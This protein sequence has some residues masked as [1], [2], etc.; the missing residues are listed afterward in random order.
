MSCLE[1]WGKGPT[2][3]GSRQGTGQGLQHSEAPGTRLPVFGVIPLLLAQGP[4]VY[5]HQ[6]MTS[7]LPWLG[8]VISRQFWEGI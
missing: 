5:H 2:A 4:L 8:R 1:G 6:K 3:T 7:F